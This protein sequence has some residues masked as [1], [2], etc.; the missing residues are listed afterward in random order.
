MKKREFLEEL[1]KILTKR[2]YSDKEE[3]LK[4]FEEHFIVGEQEGKSEEEIAKLLG[5]PKD[6]A[7]QFKE[8]I[9]EVIVSTVEENKDKSE[10]STATKF[11]IAMM[12]IFF[13]VVFALGIVA[14]IVGIIIG[15]LVTSVVLAI[16]GIVLI[17]VGL[18]GSIVGIAFI[19][20]GM[21]SF[22]IVFTGIGLTCFG[23][24]GTI[25]M[26]WS[27][28]KFVKLLIKYGKW[29]LKVIEGGI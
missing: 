13:N 28:I 7:E 12:L 10:N 18:I 22:A 6:I 23:I 5:D 19:T 15:L 4:D 8:D 2:K 26:V 27:S 25:F 24:L 14:G 9:E 17:V 3:V 21:L 16:V 29:N 20:S 1:D 11:V